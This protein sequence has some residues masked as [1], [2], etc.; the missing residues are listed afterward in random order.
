M[1]KHLLML[2]SWT[3]I[4]LGSI[5]FV[6]CGDD[7]DDDNNN[8]SVPTNASGVFSKYSG[9]KGARIDGDNVINV[10]TVG[11]QTSVTVITFDG[12]KIVSGTAYIDCLSEEAAKA[13]Y[14]EAKAEGENVSVEGRYLISKWDNE[15]IAEYDGLDKESL[16]TGLNYSNSLL[17]QLENGELSF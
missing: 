16:V 8:S 13:A 11:G 14:E 10:T 12:S 4:L 9:T 7:D 2:L 6:S 1:K 3:M 15:D 5:S 17:D